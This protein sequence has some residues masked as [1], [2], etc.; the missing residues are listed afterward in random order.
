[1][2]DLKNG[3]MEIRHKNHDFDEKKDY[4]TI[5]ILQRNYCSSLGLI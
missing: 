4:G 1:M 5:L 2:L 3:G